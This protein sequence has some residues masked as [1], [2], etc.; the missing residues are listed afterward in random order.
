MFLDPARSRAPME[1]ARHRAGGGEATLSLPSLMSGRLQEVEQ[2]QE[3]AYFQC[4]AMSA[5]IAGVWSR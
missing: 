4:F 1:P 3:G 2:F 5:L